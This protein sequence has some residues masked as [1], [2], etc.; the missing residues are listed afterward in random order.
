MMNWIA[1]SPELWMLAT[2]GVFLGRSMMRPNPGRDHLLALVMAA[3]AAG[4]AV[5]G[6]GSS[7][8]LF[9]GTYRVDLF[10]QFYKCL[11]ATGFFLVVSLCRDMQGVR[12]DLQTEFYLL[13]A[14]CTLAMMM[15]VSSVHLLTIYITLELSSYSLYILVSLRRDRDQGVRAGL[16]YFLVGA[17]ASAV[18]L[19][20]LA[21][22]YGTTGSAYLVDLLAALPVQAGQ[23]AFSLGLLL[24]L[25]GFLFKLAIF[26]FHVWAPDVYEGAANPVAA[27]IATASKVAAVGIL[28]RLAALGTT[29]YFVHVLAVLAI[30]SMTLGN[31]AAIAQTDFKRML[32]YSSIAQG[33]YILIGILSMD[34]T[35]YAAATFYA[36][37]VLVMK[38]TCFMVVVMVAAGDENPT[39][40]DL[41]GLHRRAPVMAMALMMALF[42]LG[43]IPP[44]IGFTGKLLLFTAAMS[45]GHFTLVL[46][47]M[48][49]V[50]ISLYYYL[51][52]LRA[53]Y[54]LDP[55]PEAPAFRETL[56]LKALSLAMIAAMVVIGF[57]PNHL[58]E[59]TR[60]AAALIS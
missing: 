5:M 21:L 36:F 30:A 12:E 50:V 11:L 26:P 43:G 20:G 48:I 29:A 14:V 46:I 18:M 16:K 60:R 39:L 57:Y 37:A 3:V 33:G 22:V 27:Y 45:K 44:T 47:A 32:A 13:L 6:A 19:F 15:L 38:F 41:A 55:P 51:R 2:I 9:A 25:G 54:F 58:I 49:N 59:L 34:A 10:S 35:G 52:V 53:A 28:V 17:S 24:I 42:G 40:A 56:P 8:E 23:P 7:A 31:L 4:I 1:L